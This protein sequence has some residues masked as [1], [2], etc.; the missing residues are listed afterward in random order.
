MRRKRLQDAPG[1]WTTEG[2]FFDDAD[3]PPVVACTTFEAASWR[4]MPEILCKTVRRTCGQYRREVK[5]G[6]SR[7]VSLRSCSSLDGRMRVSKTL[8]SDAHVSQ[9]VCAVD[10]IG[11]G[12]SR[13]AVQAS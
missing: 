6:Q 9:C 8:C 13:T 3:P 1:Y 7:M 5:C 4:D 12:T 10:P 11:A 2:Y